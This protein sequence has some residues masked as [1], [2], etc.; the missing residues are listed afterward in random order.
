METSSNLK[1]YSYITSGHLLWWNLTFWWLPELI[2]Q[3][4]VRH[5]G[6]WQVLILHCLQWHL[7]IEVPSLFHFTSLGGFWEA[8][9]NPYRYKIFTQVV[10]IPQLLYSKFK[11]RLLQAESKAGLLKHLLSEGQNAL[12]THWSL[13][14]LDKLCFFAFFLHRPWFGRYW[15]PLKQKGV[16][17]LFITYFFLCYLLGLKLRF[18]FCQ[19]VFEFLLPSSK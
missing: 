17:T 16:A 12:G 11:H 13:S 2:S 15:K 9:V 19:F 10:F 4:P 6:S 7:G 14:E 18:F 8:R 1:K 3:G 5:L